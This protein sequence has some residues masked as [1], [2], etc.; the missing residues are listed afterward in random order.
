M[1]MMLLSGGEA[2][3]GMIKYV[4]F[5]GLFSFVVLGVGFLGTLISSL[6]FPRPG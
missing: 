3:S 2:V 4:S 6:S 5:R 1:R